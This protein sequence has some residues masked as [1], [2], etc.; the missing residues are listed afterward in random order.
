MS[1][2]LWLRRACAVRVSSRLMLNSCFF[3]VISL[4][5]SG[6]FGAFAWELLVDVDVLSVLVPGVLLPLLVGLV[7][8][9]V[10]SC[11]LC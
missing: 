10:V 11:C 4:A 7:P 6:V 1:A 8:F 5:Q 9:C 3:V 2:W